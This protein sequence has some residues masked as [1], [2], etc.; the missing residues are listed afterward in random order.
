MKHLVII[1]AQ[2][3]G[4]TFLYHL[5]D[6]HPDVMMSKPVRPEPKYF[7]DCHAPVFDYQDYARALFPGIHAHQVRWLGE[8]STSYYDNEEVARRISRFLPDALIILI[9]RDPVK[10]AISNF[11]FSRKHG[12]ETRSLHEVFIARAEPPS[13]QAKVSVDPFAYLERGH[14]F[15]C[16][17]T[18]YRYF[19]AERIVLLKFE[20]LIKG[21]KELAYLADRLDIDP[22]GFAS[23]TKLE[24]NSSSGKEVDEA[25]ETTL[26]TYYGASNRILAEKYAFNIDGWL[27]G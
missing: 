3:G 22:D 25:L 11:K 12:L 10:R 26:A 5:L 15:R 16:L 24:K 18:F 8:K 4:S 2:R 19:P 17:D 1:G 9:L 23:P 14:Y 13:L 20:E 27:A 21:E 6:S 7:L